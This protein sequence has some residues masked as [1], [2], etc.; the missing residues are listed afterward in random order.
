MDHDHHHAAPDIP[1]GAETAKD[2]VCGMTVA[3]KPDGRNA[4]WEWAKLG[5]RRV[6]VKFLERGGVD[7]GCA[8]CCRNDI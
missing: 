1:T 8:N 2:P 6:R 7:H 5:G 4:E 3:V